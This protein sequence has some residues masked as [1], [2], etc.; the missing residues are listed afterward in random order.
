MI[1]A[2]VASSEKS[3]SVRGQAVR[4][5]EAGRDGGEREEAAVARGRFRK[6]VR[7]KEVLPRARGAGLVG[8]TRAPAIEARAEVEHQPAADVAVL[9]EKALASGVVHRGQGLAINLDLN[10]RPEK[11]PVEDRPREVVAGA[12]PIPPPFPPELHVVG[13]REPIV[14]EEEESGVCLPAIPREELVG[15]GA[16]APDPAR[17]LDPRVGVVRELGIFA[18]GKVEV[19][20][21]EARVEKRFVAEEPRIEPLKNA[22]GGVLVERRCRSRSKPRG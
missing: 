11:I 12:R 16:S 15:A 21:A 14:G 5:T 18:E 13:A 20:E 9:D 8:I 19:H 17:E 4:E 22:S 3:F 10:P 7:S 6:A 2:A 1:E